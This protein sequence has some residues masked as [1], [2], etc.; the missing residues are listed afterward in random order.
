MAVKKVTH[1][2]GSSYEMTA[3]A[4]DGKV[5]RRRFATRK[6]AAD[7]YAR[8]RAA[9][10]DGTFIAAERARISFVDSPRR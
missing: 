6:Q 3:V 5:V 4:G 2:K 7:E 8:L 10:N 9:V 1:G